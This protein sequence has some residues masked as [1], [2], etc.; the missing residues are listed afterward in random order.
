MA[1][2]RNKWQAVVSA[3]MNRVP[4]TVVNLLPS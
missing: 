4:K 2:A 1:Q 3:V